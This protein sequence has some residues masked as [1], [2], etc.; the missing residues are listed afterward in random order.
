MRK[1]SG[2]ISQSGLSFQAADYGHEHITVPVLG[3]VLNVFSSD[4]PLGV[5]ARTN[6]DGRGSQIE[7]KVLVI[8]D[9]NDSPWVLSNV[10]VCPSSCSGYDNFSEEV[11]HGVTK[12]ID[13]SQLNNLTQLGKLDGDYCVIAFIGGS[14]SQPFMLCWWPHPQNNRDP[15]TSMFKPDT[16]F[17]GVR[18]AKRW[19]GSRLVITSQGTL[20]VD[21]SE[22]NQ[23]L[24]KGKRDA[25]GSEDKGGDINVTVK[26]SRA[27]DIDFNPPVFNPLEPDFLWPPTHVEQER[28]T[29]STHIRFTKDEI[30]AIAGE[31]VNIIAQRNDI[32]L[33]T[34]EGKIMFGAGADQQAILGNILN[35]QLANIIDAVKASNVPTAWGPSGP[36]SAGAGAPL[37][38]AVKADLPNNLSEFIYTKKTKA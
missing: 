7:A 9:G 25:P 36:I 20:F 31:M 11:P 16:L 5:S 34:P 38:D 23:F 13:E 37:L 10:V 27:L 28:K 35:T 6:H 18:W 32:V 33:S 17:Q 3:M 24:K 30:S 22:A 19:Q 15:V 2:T 1:R 29:E 8:N 14:V 21:T 26:E 4:N 12:A